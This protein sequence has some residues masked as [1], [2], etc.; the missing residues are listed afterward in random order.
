MNWKSATKQELYVILGFDAMATNEDR[1][2]A[3][4]ELT[5]RARQKRRY[6]RVN[7]KLKAVY[8]R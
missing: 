8:P 5:R 2:A 3:A 1:H 6:D 4:D 7:Q